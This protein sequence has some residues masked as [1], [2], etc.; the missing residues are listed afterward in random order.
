MTIL[1]RRL[2]LRLAFL[3]FGV[4]N[5]YAFD[6]QQPAAKTVVSPS[7]T[8]EQAVEI[9]QQQLAETRTY[10]DNERRISVSIRAADLLWPYHEA[11]ARAAFSEA[12]D[13]AIQFHREKG[14][15]PKQD[16]GML[17]GMPDV[18][19]TVITAIARRDSAW[20]RKMTDKMVDDLAEEAKETGSPNKARE[21]QMAERL[22]E[23]ANSLVDTNQAAALSFAGQTLQFPATMHLTVFIYRLAGVNRPVADQFYQPRSP[24][25]P[26][27]PWIGF[28]TCRL[29]HSEM[30]GMREICQ[31]V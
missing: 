24:P 13:L 15:A 22:L 4:V 5:T 29:F 21:G 2:L 20:A 10:D 16:G 25:T 14:S 27:R 23:M 17:I 12:F 1:S 9:V 18:R 26:R 19:F 30:N 8:S 6:Q 7:C 28:F 11:Q 31:V 3:M